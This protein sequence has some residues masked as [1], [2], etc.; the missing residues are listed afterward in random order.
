[1]KTLNQSNQLIDKVTQGKNV[2]VRDLVANPVPQLD[3]NVMTAINSPVDTLS[4]ELK[5]IQQL[6]DELIAELKA[7][8]T[9]IIGAPMYNFS[10]PT[11]LKNYFDIMARAGVTF[12]YTEQGPQGLIGDRKVIVVTTRGGIHKDQQTDTIT[13]Y[14]KSILG[15][16]GITTV[17][18][19]YAEGLSMGDEMADKSREQALEELGEPV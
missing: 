3:L 15:F 13:P 10:V 7:A 19:I 17:E 16:I 14:L 9:V 18:V 6:S 4:A 5:Q 11:Q 8:D 1:V 2:T 12:Q